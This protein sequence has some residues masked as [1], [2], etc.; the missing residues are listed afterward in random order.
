MLERLRNKTI[1]IEVYE[2]TVVPIVDY[3][4]SI[5]RENQSEGIGLRREGRKVVFYP[6]DLQPPPETV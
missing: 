3:W 5:N 6:V 2:K 1:S 4:W